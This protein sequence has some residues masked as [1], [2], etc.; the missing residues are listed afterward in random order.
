MGAGTVADEGSVGDEAMDIW[1]REQATGSS[2]A[3]SPLQDAPPARS[4]RLGPGDAACLALLA[5]AVLGMAAA[6]V[7]ILTDGPTAID[8]P[9]MLL[10]AAAGAVGAL[11]A[12]RGGAGIVGWAV[13]A[14]VS[15]VA[16]ALFLIPLLLIL[17]ALDC[18]ASWLADC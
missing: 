8:G 12:R 10:P 1:R 4:R 11:A 14:S 13:V 18:W 17:D 9:A 7:V 5:P 3:P 15:A 6:L 2:S 16:L